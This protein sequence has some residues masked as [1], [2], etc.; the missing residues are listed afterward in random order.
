MFLLKITLLLATFVACASACIPPF[1]DFRYIDNT[2]LLQEV[3]EGWERARAA[4]M[5]WAHV[6][7]GRGPVER[8][9]KGASGIVHINY[10]FWDQDTKVSPSLIRGLLQANLTFSWS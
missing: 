1:N 6:L 10:C 3:V 9:P 4:Q 8:W 2:T 5:D 7:D